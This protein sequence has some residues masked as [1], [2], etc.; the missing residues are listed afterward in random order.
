ML[1]VSGSARL[2][3][4]LAAAAALFLASGAAGVPVRGGHGFSV[5]AGGG[6]FRKD[7][8][9]CAH[10]G[11]ALNAVVARA[12][13]AATVFQGRVRSKSNGPNAAGLYAYTFTVQKV[14]KDSSPTPLRPRQ[15]LRFWFKEK[16]SSEDRGGGGGGGRGGACY[17]SYY[18]SSRPHVRANIRSGAKYIVFANGVG[19][20]NLSAF[21]EPI[22]SVT[23]NRRAV[24][25][26]IKNPC[27]YNSH[28]I[29]IYRS[30]RLR[31]AKS[32]R[33]VFN[34]SRCS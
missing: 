6:R 12:F 21:G 27:K 10:K 1:C 5:Q 8:P 3:A 9:P 7:D 13:M 28:L 26:A 34:V 29:I 19:P 20:H 2:A 11:D 25:V 16:R 24:D 14:F 4:A 17:Q 32:R 15:T 18:N 33:G 23:K 22:P 31:R 30:T